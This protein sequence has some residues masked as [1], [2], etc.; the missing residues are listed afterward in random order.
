MFNNKYYKKFKG[1]PEEK[2]FLELT[3]Y[4][5]KSFANIN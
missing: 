5:P 3:G 1:T 2:K 4:I